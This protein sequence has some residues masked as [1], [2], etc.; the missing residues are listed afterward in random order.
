MFIVIELGR[1]LVAI[2]DP[3]LGVVDCELYNQSAEQVIQ[4]NRDSDS[5]SSSC[6]HKLI[7][8][9]P[10]NNSHSVKALSSIIG[11]AQIERQ[12]RPTKYKPSE[13]PP[14]PAAKRARR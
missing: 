4:D 9:S 6:D 10:H 13:K 5:M 11:L 14:A 3:R 7:S 1:K 2:R 8:M 12:E